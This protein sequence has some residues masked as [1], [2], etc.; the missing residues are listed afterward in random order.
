MMTGVC[1]MICNF[2][3]CNNINELKELFDFGTVGLPYVYVWMFDKYTFPV[4]VSVSFEANFGVILNDIYS[5]QLSSNRANIIDYEDFRSMV[6]AIL[7]Q[8]L[9]TL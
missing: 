8:K 9:L 5:H 7:H 1:C 3:K 4:Y 6:S 2:V